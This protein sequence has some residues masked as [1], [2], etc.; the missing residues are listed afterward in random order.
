MPVS[1]AHHC[2]FCS[3]SFDTRQ[4]LLQHHQ[5]KHRPVGPQLGTDLSRAIA[6]LPTDMR[7]LSKRMDAGNQQTI[8]VESTPLQIITINAPRAWVKWLDTRSGFAS[9]SEAIRVAIRDFIIRQTAL[10]EVIVEA[11]E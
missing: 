1:R 6:T 10:E 3:A 11:N 2:P 8:D 9:R 7:K 4:A 5:Y